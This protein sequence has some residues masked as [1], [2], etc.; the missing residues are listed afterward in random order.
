MKK[1]YLLLVLL[2]TIIY[3]ECILANIIY[4]PDDQPTIQA[5]ISIASEGDTVLVDP[6]IY[7]EVINF[8]GKNI[9]VASL[10]LTTG[11]HDYIWQTIIDGND[12]NYCLV[13]FVSGETTEAKFIGFTVRNANTGYIALNISGMG[14][15]IVD[16][17]PIV[18]FNI[19]EDNYCFWY[20]NGC[21]IGL[22]NS[23]AIIRNNIIRNNDGAYYGGG[24]SIEE[25]YGVV[26][27]NNEIYGNTTQSG[28]G[29]A[30][31]GGICV[32][33]SDSITIKGNLI[34]SNSVDVG[35]GGGIA[36]KTSNGFLVNN[37]VT[38]NMVNGAGSG[39]FL[40][41]YSS[42]E[43]KNNIIWGNFPMYSAQVVAYNVD[44]TFSLIQGGYEGE[45]N[46]NLN[47][48]FLNPSINDYTLTL[49]S[50]C[51]NTGD[52]DL[53][54]DPDG[55]LPDM[56][57]KYFDMTGYGTVT[58]Q[59]NLNGGFGSVIKVIIS[60]DDQ[61]TNPVEDGLYKLNLVPG[62][63]NLLAHLEGYSDDI[64]SNISVIQGQT[65]TGIDF[66]LNL[67]YLNH[68]IHI[69][70]DSS[71][72]FTTIQEGIN[73]AI[74]GDTILVYPGYY[75]EN[76]VMDKNLVV[77]GLYLINQDTSNID[78]TILNGATADHA[79]FLEEN[80][81][82]YT[83]ISGLSF[84]NSDYDYYGILAYNT[85]VKIDHCYFKNQEDIY[86]G[87]V[88]LMFC[89]NSRIENCLFTDEFHK[90]HGISVYYSIDV[91][92]LGNFFINNSVALSSHYSTCRIAFNHFEDNSWGASGAGK[93]TVIES[94]YFIGNMDGIYCSEFSSKICNN[95]FYNSSD[96][97]YLSEYSDP[98]I[99]N[100]LIFNATDD[101][102][103]CGMSSPSIINNT[104]INCGTGISFYAES[105][106]KVINNIIWGNESSFW[107][108]PIS[109]ITIS[110][111]CIE[112]EFPPNATDGGGNIYDYPLFMDTVNS[113]YHLMPLSPC[114]NAGTP[115]TTGL[116][117]PP[118][119]LD[120]HYRIYG[121]A[122][123]M[124]PYEL[125][126]TNIESQKAEEEIYL[127]IYP[128]PFID[129]VSIVVTGK[130]QPDSD[131]RIYGPDGKMIIYNQPPD[132][133]SE[134]FCTWTWDGYDANRKKV[135]PGLYILEISLGKVKKT[136]NLIML[137]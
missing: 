49:Q 100:N 98:L 115:D 10:F 1:I 40:S 132:L 11:N 133:K 5:G 119:D 76:V 128:N 118:L 37:T 106:A 134:D 32:V 126:F 56:G 121:E 120:G 137:E 89:R 65:I 117:I 45:G 38:N 81:S 101:G 6:G 99:A 129:K 12:V 46:L 48:I 73:A 36:F 130:I 110:Y 83:Q 97:V 96:A 60:S 77:G 14:I 135:K 123:E 21:G 15:R 47:P 74:D 94:N 20:I 80:L 84:I 79:L 127:K 109:D 102:I 54:P 7:Y 95:Y 63:Y 108:P 104:I 125:L 61:Y 111:S 105:V 93:G 88:S 67:N 19:V 57:H 23:S 18:E 28:N 87:R 8:S 16:S 68:I 29:V 90:R 103:T 58:G 26:I 34:H 136:G 124:G 3:A 113:D 42:A 66:N 22:M 17:S 78:A 131:F 69:K 50:P 27:E 35:E 55:T 59:V 122:I 24:I 51:I 9:T 75:E 43:I 33:S 72:D 107:V 70:Q 4:V 86:G 53:D 25:S 31:G 41:Q 82:S 114:F 39:F 30:Y 71:G 2:T 64:I 112:G 13:S 116:K 44:V 91:N 52:P 62:I 92:I 85:T